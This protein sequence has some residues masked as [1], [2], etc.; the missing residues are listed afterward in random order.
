MIDF[1][2]YVFEYAASNMYAA[3]EDGRGLVI[4]PFVS[5]EALAYLKENSVSDITILLTH[6]HYDHISG[7]KWLSDRFGSA[8]I[9]QEKTA[10]A[11]ASG[12]NNRP[13]MVSAARSNS[14]SPDE[15]KSFLKSLP[16][17]FFCTADITFKND[18]YLNWQEHCI[19]MIHCPGHSPGSCCIEIDDDIV[20]TG[21]SLI[22]NT[23]VIT[24]FPGGS[25]EEYRRVTVPYLNG[26]GDNVRILPGHGEDDVMGSLTID[27]I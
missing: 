6:E 1:Q 7:V 14:N 16:N 9:C 23:P 11:L 4:D 8:V 3:A 13:V 12:K 22:P 10:E 21:D 24:R 15:I 26:I 5:G 18:Y 19:H 17:G 2:R 27:F 25:E 20:V